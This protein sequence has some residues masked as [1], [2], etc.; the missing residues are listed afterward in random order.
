M[1]FDS[2]DLDPI[3]YD[4]MFLADG[5][6]RVACRQLHEALLDLSAEEL[7]SIQERVTRSF[8][9]EGITFTVYGDAEA[10]ERI[11]PVDCVPRVLSNA[12][13]RHLES[14]LAQRLRTLNLFLEDVYDEAKWWPTASYRRRGV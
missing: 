1:D 14:G 6:S 8:S 10:D 11:I 12:D 7:A 9:N 5:S 3:F 2:Y 13:W 4:E